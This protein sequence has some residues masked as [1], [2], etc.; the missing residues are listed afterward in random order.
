M[1]IPHFRAQRSA[2][3]RNAGLDQRF[4][5]TLRLVCSW[6]A[7]SLLQAASS[8]GRGRRLEPCTAHQVNQRVTAITASFRFDWDSF[9]SLRS[10][11]KAARILSAAKYARRTG[12]LFRHRPRLHGGK[13]AHGL[14]AFEHP[15]NTRHITHTLA[16]HWP[17][18]LKYLL[19]NLGQMRF[20]MRAPCLQHPMRLRGPGIQKIVINALFFCHQVDAYR[21]F[22]G[23]LRRQSSQIWAWR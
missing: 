10:R 13:T 11:F 6:T 23:S 3:F 18:I 7:A 21:S 9:R 12:R 5:N 16:I 20:A 22:K 19:C 15:L 14:A 4:P 8:H 1:Y 17:V 2:G